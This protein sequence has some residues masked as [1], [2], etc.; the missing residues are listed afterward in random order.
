MAFFSCTLKRTNAFELITFVAVRVMNE[1]NSMHLAVFPIMATHCSNS[2]VVIVHF[3]Q[4][5]VNQRMENWDYYQK[6]RLTNWKILSLFV[7][8]CCAWVS[9][10]SPI[11]QECAK[12]NWKTE[13]TNAHIYKAIKNNDTNPNSFA[14]CDTRHFQ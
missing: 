5:Y 7:R 10:I 6:Y 4:F 14:L 2:I 9:I 3:V 8:Y 13:F 11:L 12:T 1:Q